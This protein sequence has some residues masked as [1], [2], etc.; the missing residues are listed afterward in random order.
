MYRSFFWIPFPF[1]LDYWFL[2]PIFKL[3][4]NKR[5]KEE[6][7]YLL[8]RSW[9]WN[10]LLWL[11]VREASPW[12][13]ILMFVHLL[14]WGGQLSCLWLRKIWYIVVIISR[15]K[16]VFHAVAVSKSFD[17]NWTLYT[18]LSTYLCIGR[19]G[20]YFSFQKRQCGEAGAPHWPH[21]DRANFLSPLSSF[22]EWHRVACRR[23]TPSNILW[24]GDIQT[25]RQYKLFSLEQT[26]TMQGIVAF[27]CSTAESKT[28]IYKKY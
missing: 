4:L 25:V 28:K 2:Q 10:I 1:L 9:H 27:W 24:R 21:I 7:T 17:L 26:T 8:R 6:K 11:L 3:V 15:L 12:L 19:V 16:R 13:R 20:G 22:F 14:R 5:E 23:L 18:R